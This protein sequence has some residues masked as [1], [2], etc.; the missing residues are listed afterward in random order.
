MDQQRTVTIINKSGIAQDYVIFAEEPVI[1][2]SAAHIKTNVI[3]ALRGVAGH[4]GQ[5]FFAMPKKR[6]YAMCG[7]SNS[8]GIKDLVQIDILDQR[9]VKLETKDN[10]GLIEPGTTCD[11]T[12]QNGTPAFS[13]TDH[14]TPLGIQG[15]FGIHTAGDFS[16]QEAEEGA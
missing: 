3:V 15:S 9:A 10:H 5:A 7:T 12:V 8:D 13:A 11:V 6:L 1:D 4:E 16:Y 2:P 14:K